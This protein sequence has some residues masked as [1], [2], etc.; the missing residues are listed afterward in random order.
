MLLWPVISIGGVRKFLESWMNGAGEM[1]LQV[2]ALLSDVLECRREIAPDPLSDLFSANAAC[3][4][5]DRQAVAAYP[6]RGL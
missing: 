6:V 1:H 4:R 3:R 2:V 5:V